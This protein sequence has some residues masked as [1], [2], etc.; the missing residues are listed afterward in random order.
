MSFRVIPANAYEFTICKD[1]K[2]TTIQPA[3][4][5]ATPGDTVAIGKGIYK[6]NLSIEKSITLRGAGEAKT[7]IKPA[8]LGKPVLSIGPGEGTVNIKGVTVKGAR[9]EGEEMKDLYKASGLLVHGQEKQI[10]V[11]NCTFEDNDG[12]GI[13]LKGSHKLVGEDIKAISNK[14]GGLLVRDDSVVAISNSAFVNNE[15]GGIFAEG[16]R[17]VNLYSNKFSGNTRGV[18]F[19]LSPQITLRNNLIENNDIGVL[20]YGDLFRGEVKGSGNIIRGGVSPPLEWGMKAGLW[21]ENFLSS[22][23]T[24]ST[25]SKKFPYKDLSLPEGLE[26]EYVKYDKLLGVER[27]E[28]FPSGPEVLVVWGK[29]K[30]D[31]VPSPK[32]DPIAYR[33]YVINERGRLMGISGKL[34]EKSHLFSFYYNDGYGWEPAFYAPSSEGSMSHNDVIDVRVEDLI[35]SSSGEEVMITYKPSSPTNPVKRFLLNWAGDRLKV[36]HKSSYD[37]YQGSERYDFNTYIRQRSVNSG[38]EVPLHSTPGSFCYKQYRFWDGEEYEVLKEELTWWGFDLKADLKGFA[39]KALR[40]Y[41]KD[42]NSGLIQYRSDPV[43]LARHLKGRDRTKYWLASKKNGLAII[44]KLE[45]QKKER[46]FAYQPFYEKRESSDTIWVLT[47]EDL[48]DKGENLE[49]NG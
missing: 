10:T 3:I 14:K 9:A 20:T 1:C 31:Y 23:L 49:E 26:F 21:P 24:F 47:S 19:Y 48:Y 5:A 18:H 29:G 46:L 16:G 13:N 34:A 30:I 38:F 17:I 35:Y 45:G 11:E 44:Y 42:F 22:S 27:Q 28:L 4:D 32:F 25:K 12:W 6:E 41:Q 8:E 7:I 40:E 37:R 43:R 39:T 2:H 33:P 15:G 36:F